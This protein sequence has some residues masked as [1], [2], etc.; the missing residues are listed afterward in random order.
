MNDLNT[1]SNQI[2]TFAVTYLLH[3]TLL[4]AACWVV[5]KVVRA[6]SH[7]LRERM[8]KLAAVLGILTAASQIALGTA[9]QVDPPWLRPAIVKPLPATELSVARVTLLEA[10]SRLAEPHVRERATNEFAIAPPTTI[11]LEELPEAD[12][13]IV[14]DEDAVEEFPTGIELDFQLASPPPAIDLAE[15]DFRAVAAARETDEADSH[16]SWFR[17]VMTWITGTLSILLACCVGLGGAVLVMQSMRL[18]TR[19][20]R[21]TLLT[22]GPAR[23]TLD[24]FLKR[25]QIRRKIRLLSST[26]HSEPVTYGLLRWTIILPEHTEERLGREELKALLAHEVAH[27]VRGDVWWLWIGRVLCTCLVFQPLNWLARRKWQQA[28]EYLCDDWA[29]E[30]GIRSIS[31]ARCLTQIAEWRFGRAACELGLA[32]GGTKATLVQRVERLVEEERRADRWRQPLRRRLVTLGA[33]IAVV[34]LAG[35]APRVALPLT[36]VSERGGVG[37]VSAGRSADDLT[38]R[39][40]QALE[41]ELLQLEADLER[42]GELRSPKHPAEVTAH[43]QNL[44]R[45]AASLRARREHIT[46]LLGKDSQR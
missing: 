36:H 35:F 8:W 43:I 23:R 39:D 1:F 33:A 9:S 20:S 18:R 34:G 29:V 40:W 2:A 3:S 46:S 41:E 4:L 27:L 25:H 10:D 5:L 28:A 14:P 16:S 13:F 21:A 44:D 12:G 19:F 32:A 26:T 11:I 24:R 30:R 22:E 31:L 17:S 38:T 6:K 42:I 45:R 7:Y 37:E 15:S